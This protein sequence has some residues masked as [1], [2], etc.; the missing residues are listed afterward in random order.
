[1]IIRADTPACAPKPGL[2]RAL[3]VDARLGEVD[4]NGAR[5]G[6]PVAPIRTVGE[7]GG[8]AGVGE[9]PG[10]VRPDCQL[11][12]A[13]LSHKDVARRT[14]G[15]RSDP[16]FARATRAIETP[17]PMVASTI[18]R[19]SC[20]DRRTRFSVCPAWFQVS[21]QLDSRHTPAVS[22]RPSPDV[23]TTSIDKPSCL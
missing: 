15:W 9:A 1:M 8:C 10:R 12:R 3:D 21:S 23:Y 17:V 16:P 2:R 11:G 4:L 20:L 19:R 13:D 14:P 18:R 7:C 22:R 5:S 6:V